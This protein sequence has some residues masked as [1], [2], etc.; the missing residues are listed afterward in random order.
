MVID[1]EKLKEIK[2]RLFRL[3]FND[4][5]AL[6]FSEHDQ[7][8]PIKDTNMNH[9][10]T[11]GIYS[12]F[13]WRNSKEFFGKPSEDL[14][15]HHLDLDPFDKKYTIAC[16]L[17]VFLGSFGTALNGKEIY[18]FF[19]CKDVSTLMIAFISNISNINIQIKFLPRKYNIYQ[20]SF[21]FRTHIIY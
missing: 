6:R 4:K 5:K 18:T 2:K 12:K 10:N 13:F 21:S 14:T 11:Q 8:R 7:D 1:I 20:L 15:S 16:C 17:F 9:S 3:Q 19:L